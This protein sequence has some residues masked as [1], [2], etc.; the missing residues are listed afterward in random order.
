MYEF[1]IC[2]LL[3]P[4]II[5]HNEAISWWFRKIH[6]LHRPL[7]F[8]RK[9]PIS[10]AL[11]SSNKFQIIQALRLG[12]SDQP[13]KVRLKISPKNWYI[14]NHRDSNC[15]VRWPRR[16]VRGWNRQQVAKRGTGIGGFCFNSLPRVRCGAWLLPG[17]QRHGI[18]LGGF[19]FAG[20]IQSVRIF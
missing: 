20:K 3:W 5:H 11:R 1:A 2:L 16:F 18:L 9:L 10:S 13:N 6:C 19:G 12:P 15:D 17:R 7:S 8:R 14:P 4:S